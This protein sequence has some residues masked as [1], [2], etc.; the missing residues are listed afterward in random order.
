MMKLT[1]L[2]LCLVAAVNAFVV[3]APVAMRTRSVSTMR[4]GVDPV[5]VSTLLQQGSRCLMMLRN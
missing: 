1:A 3:P 2:L 4:M 5:S